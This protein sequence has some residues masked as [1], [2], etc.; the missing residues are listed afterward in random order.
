M[1]REVVE[2]QRDPVPPHAVELARPSGRLRLTDGTDAPRAI[3]GRGE[4]LGRDRDRVAVDAELAGPGA[5]AG[6][7]RRV[8]QDA[9]TLPAYM[10]CGSA[11]GP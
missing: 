10:C 8:E 3:A 5:D 11:I 2:A 7:A 9:V 6:E 4:A 1:Q